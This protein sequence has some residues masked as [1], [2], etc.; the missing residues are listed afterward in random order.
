M[1]KKIEIGKKPSKKNA[2]TW[3]KEGGDK[4]STTGKSKR[5]TTDVDEA[6]HRKIKVACAAKGL[7]MADEI[8][9]ILE[10]KFQ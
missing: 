10:K 3:I 6:L 9:A 4:A 2:D 8:R 7:K 1:A 5:L